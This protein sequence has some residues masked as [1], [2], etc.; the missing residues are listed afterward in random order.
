METVVDLEL[1]KK[2]EIK[3]VILLLSRGGVRKGLLE[4]A[5]GNF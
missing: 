2:R 1:G 4:N 5:V 3:V